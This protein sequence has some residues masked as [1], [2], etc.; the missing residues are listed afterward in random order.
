MI[1]VKIPEGIKA[2][3]KGSVIEVT[4]PLGTNKRRMS[5]K[6]LTIKK[7]GETLVIEGIKNKKLAKKGVAAENS[8]AKE[9]K[10][11]MAGVTKHFEAKMKIV[12]AHFPISIEIKGNEV[13]INNMIGERAARISK[14][15]GNTKVEVKGQDIR[16]YGTSLDDVGQTAANLRSVVKI[17]D[18]DSRTFQDGIYHSIGE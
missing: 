11:D 9:L 14:I 18:K 12:F 7:S 17:R 1:E 13:K 2:E 5:D 3:I 16:V 4:G 8:F 15:V 10:N 6:F